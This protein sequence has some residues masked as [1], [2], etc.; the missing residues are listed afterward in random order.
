MAL[1]HKM[2]CPPHR[3]CAPLSLYWLTIEKL[4]S[5]A[6]RLM[7]FHTPT[8]GSLKLATRSPALEKHGCLRAADDLHF[9]FN[10]LALAR[11]A[12]TTLLRKK[13]NS[14]KKC[15]FNRPKDVLQLFRCLRKYLD[16]LRHFKYLFTIRMPVCV[17][18]HILVSS[19]P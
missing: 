16:I 12:T 18:P 11:S 2:P 17:S 19:S 10:R 7:Q 5:L 3:P 1:T 8:G 14:I 13:E 6:L 9:N 15:R 4:L